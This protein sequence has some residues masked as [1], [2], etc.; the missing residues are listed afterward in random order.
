MY[1]KRSEINQRISREYSLI[2]NT[3]PQGRAYRSYAPSL[4]HMYLIEEGP[5]RGSAREGRVPREGP[6]K[7]VRQRGGPI[8]KV[9]WRRSAEEDSTEKIQWRRSDGE[10]PLEKVRQRRSVGE[11]GSLQ[12][13]LWL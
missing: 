11:D 9:R 2:L 10:G 3:L 1:K 6:S 7:R 8:E 5:W 4:L 13:Q 12:N